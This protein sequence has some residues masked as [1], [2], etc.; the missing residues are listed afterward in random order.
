MVPSRTLARGRDPLA[1]VFIG[2]NNAVSAVFLNVHQLTLAV[3]REQRADG[4]C[5]NQ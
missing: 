3:N 5:L 1:A 4:K 2:V